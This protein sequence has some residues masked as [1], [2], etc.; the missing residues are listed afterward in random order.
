MAI[1]KIT[2][3]PAHWKFN[4]L[5]RRKTFKVFK[6]GRGGMKS[7]ECAKAMV[8]Y[9]K[10]FPR[11]FGVV[12]RETEV[13][14]K[15]SA[16]KLIWDTIVRYGLDGEFDN[17][18]GVI[19]HKTNG[20]FVV[21][22]G[23]GADPD[24]VKSM[25][26]ADVVWVEEAQDASD[27]SF[28]TLIPTIIRKDGAEVWF[29]YNPRF[30][31]DAVSVMFD[32]GHP[33]AEIQTIN[34]TENPFISQTFIIEAEEMR[35]KNPKL[36]E[37]VYLGAYLDDSTLVMCPRVVFGIG[38]AYPNDICVVGV[39]IARSGGDALVIYVRKG[40]NIVEKQKHY[41][42]DLDSL[43]SQLMDVNRRWNPDR[44]NIDSTGHGAWC[45]DGLKKSGFNNVHAINFSEEAWD[46][47]KY[48]KKR[49]NLYA[50]ANQYFDNGGMIQ[51]GD[52][53]LEKQ[54]IS[55]RYTF[56]SKNRAQLIPKDEIKKIIGCSPDDSDAFCL[57]L[58][59]G[60]SEMFSKPYK[61]KEQNEAEIMNILMKNARW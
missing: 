60:T 5:Y 54:L 23:I 15:H 19:R 36:Y 41:N 56:D 59:T 27:E 14:L 20:S 18:I 17:L 2:F 13:S 6:G 7:W 24:S 51:V 52:T 26:G 33:L 11:F 39:D 16:Q 45:A 35:R 3:Q 40:R 12:C 61:A 21:F 22:R 50:L 32:E 25:E 46:D 57:S 48:S 30:R 58:Y 38:Q 8:Y 4:V 44:I 28:R 1:K 31:T 29:T 9:M 37:H 43:S 55:S 47:A 49:T 53:E 10:K 42:M 34:Y